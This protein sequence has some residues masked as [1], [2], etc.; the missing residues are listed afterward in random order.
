MVPQ[1]RRIDFDRGD[2]PGLAGFRR[3]DAIRG[4]EHD[5]AGQERRG[6]RIERRQADFRRGALAHV[7]DVLRPDAGLDHQLLV[8]GHDVEQRIAWADDLAHRRNA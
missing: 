7:I 4:H 2:E 8:G 6:A 5:R 1:R 3:G